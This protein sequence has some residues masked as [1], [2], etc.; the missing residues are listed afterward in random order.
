MIVLDLSN[1]ALP[2]GAQWILVPDQILE[3]CTSIH[4]DSLV[5]TKSSPAGQ[6]VKQ[7][8]SDIVKQIHA[9]RDLRAAGDFWPVPLTIP[10]G[11]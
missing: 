4:G 8:P 2:T 5:I 1:P 11:A 10:P 6:H 7:T 9:A 3:I